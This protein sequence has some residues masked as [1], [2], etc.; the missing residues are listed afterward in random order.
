MQAP[1]TYFECLSHA[2]LNDNGLHAKRVHDQC[3]MHFAS[4]VFRL[5]AQHTNVDALL[6]EAKTHTLCLRSA[7]EIAPMRAV[8]CWIARV[9]RTHPALHEEPRGWLRAY[10]KLFKSCALQLIHYHRNY[11][12]KPRRLFC[13]ILFAILAAEVFAM[14]IGLSSP[15]HIQWIYPTAG[16]DYYLDSDT[17]CI[18]LAQDAQDGGWYSRPSSDCDGMMDAWPP[19]LTH[20]DPII[21]LNNNNNNNNNDTAEQDNEQ[22]MLRSYQAKSSTNYASTGVEHHNEAIGLFTRRGPHVHVIEYHPSASDA[23]NCIYQI[24]PGDSQ[25]TLYWPLQ[26][27]HSLYAFAAVSSLQQHEKLAIEPLAHTSDHDNYLYFSLAHQTRCVLVVK[28]VNLAQA[29]ARILDSDPTF[30]VLAPA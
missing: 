20:D 25:L 4:L 22:F 15:P 12:R 19:L 16:C 1:Q 5:Q 6:R 28:A 29:Q 8:R 3:V 13:R 14:Q 24:Y 10:P 30:V 23:A 27:L 9:H 11:E 21:D 2:I 26:P 18:I 7:E 17:K